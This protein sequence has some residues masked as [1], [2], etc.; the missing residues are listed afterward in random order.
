M[1]RPRSPMMATFT[2]SFGLRRA[3]ARA[4][5]AASPTV[6]AAVF[7]RNVRRFIEPSSRCGADGSTLTKV[8]APIPR[9]S[10]A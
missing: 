9:T 3:Y 5:S 4:G 6:A 7:D 10:S 8:S 1:L 2:V